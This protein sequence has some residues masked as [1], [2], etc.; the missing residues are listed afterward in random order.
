MEPFNTHPDVD[1]ARVCQQCAVRHITNGSAV[2]VSL[3]LGRVGSE[4]IVAV[5]LMTPA[6]ARRLALDLYEAAQDADPFPSHGT[7]GSPTRRA[8]AR[9]VRRVRRPER[10]PDAPPRHAMGELPT[11]PSQCRADRTDRPRQPFRR[12]GCHRSRGRSH[13]HARQPALPHR[14]PGSQNRRK[15]QWRLPPAGAV[16]PPAAAHHPTSRHPERHTLR[17]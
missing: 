7:S 13:P 17:L 10:R 4:E 12:H 1:D 8:S 14:L 6:Q 3:K 11:L 5:H 16:L 9:P 15:T 2:I